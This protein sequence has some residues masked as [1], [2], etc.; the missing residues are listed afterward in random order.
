[1]ESYRTIGRSAEDEFVEKRS[2]FIGAVRPVSSAEEAQ[3][4]IAERRG[5]HPQA[6]HNCWAYILR[7]GGIQRYS[8]DGEPQGTAGIPML[9]V[10]R[11]EGLCDLVVV[12]T[13]YF[14]GT[15]LGAGG[16]VRAYS[17]GVTVALDAG[18]RV[19]MAACTLLTIA[20]PYPL[21]DRLI[22]LLEPFPALILDTRYTD[23]IT[24]DIRMRSDSVD[25]FTAALTELSSGSVTPG[26]TGE[27]F[28]PLE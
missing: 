11:K 3:A 26:V 19:T 8:D 13:R 25:Q 22:K 12:V 18:G 4:F 9:E 20:L 24:L 23:E 14:G 21:Y 16:L 1:M 17:H 27:V 10:L 6:N 2:R 15:L 28:A 5:M 7:E